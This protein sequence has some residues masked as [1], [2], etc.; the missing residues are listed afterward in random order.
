MTQ[1]SFDLYPQNSTAGA[2]QPA[3]SFC[4]LSVQLMTSAGVVVRNSPADL[5]EYT[6]QSAG[7]IG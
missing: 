2:A 7:V 3:V 1:G 5:A 6:F 4:E